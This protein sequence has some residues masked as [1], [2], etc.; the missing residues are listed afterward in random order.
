MKKELGWLVHLLKAK[1]VS[2]LATERTGFKYLAS[3]SDLI[4]GENRSFPV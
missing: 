4:P 3:R 1:E 2:K